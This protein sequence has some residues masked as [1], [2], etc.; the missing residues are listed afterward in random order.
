MDGHAAA[1]LRPD[2]KFRRCSS[3]FKA[4]A[5][6]GRKV[7]KRHKQNM[8]RFFEEWFANLMVS[9]ATSILDDD[10]PHLVGVGKERKRL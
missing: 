1:Y 9:M 6:L 8:I 5:L 10:T 7:L 2:R 3:R 4:I